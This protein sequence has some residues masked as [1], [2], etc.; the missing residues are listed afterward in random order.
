MC[1]HSCRPA[2]GGGHSPCSSSHTPSYCDRAQGRVPGVWGKP[3]SRCWVLLSVSL[4]FSPVHV[5]HHELYW[6]RG[7]RADY[8][9]THVP[10]RGKW[11]PGARPS[12]GGGKGLWTWRTR[13]PPS[14]LPGGGVQA[15]N[16]GPRASPSPCGTCSP[17][18]GHTRQALPRLCSCCQQLQASD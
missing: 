8:K 13:A 11:A 2:C 18:P 12:R 15:L 9:C 1:V 3:S 10:T 7:P 6:H 5:F 14:H 16:L 17:S 4:R